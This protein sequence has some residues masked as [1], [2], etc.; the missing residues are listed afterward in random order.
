I[1]PRGHCRRAAIEFPRSIDGQIHRMPPMRP[2]RSLK[3]FGADH[4]DAKALGAR[5]VFCF[6]RDD[7]W[8]SSGSPPP[9]YNRHLGLAMLASNGSKSG[10]VV[11]GC[12]HTPGSRRYL[13]GSI[14]SPLLAAFAR[15]HIQKR[16]L[17]DDWSPRP[18]LDR[19]EQPVRSS[20]ARLE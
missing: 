4:A 3:I 1:L 7:G 6:K 16:A 17:G 18:L 5:K 14:Q 20:K 10:P 2:S 11:S 13:A 9:E 8:I 19:L 12:R 15:L